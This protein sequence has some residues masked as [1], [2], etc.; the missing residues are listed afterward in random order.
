MKIERKIEEKPRFE[1]I[2]AQHIF[3]KD[4]MVSVGQELGRENGRLSQAEANKKEITS[5]LK[6][7]EDSIQARID[8]LA[9]KASNGYEFRDHKCEVKLVPKERKKQLIFN[10]EVKQEKTMTPDEFQCELP[11]PA[12]EYDSVTCINQATIIATC[13]EWSARATV[14]QDRKKVWLIGDD[15]TPFPMWVDAVRAISGIIWNRLFANMNLQIDATLQYAKANSTA[16]KSWWPKV[17]PA[18]LSRKSPY[19]TYV[20][21][22]LPPTP[23]A[24]PSVA[25]VLAALNPLNTS[26]M[27]YF[28]DNAGRFHCSDTYTEHVT[29]LKKYF[30]QGK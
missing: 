24:N 28:H 3:T 1:V 16:T 10:G 25:A 27:F 5:Q 20:H 19:N 15:P 30:G 22:G 13:G 2:Q 9:R 26:C 29:L 6:A 14:W 4:E 7:E 18:D 8:E 11:L 12:W 17:T 21:S 23:I